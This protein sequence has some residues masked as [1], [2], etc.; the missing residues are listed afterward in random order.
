MMA[1]RS[2]NVDAVKVLLDHGAQVNAKDTLRG[3]TALMWATEQ[4]HVGST[5]QRRF[6]PESH[7]FRSAP[8]QHVGNHHAFHRTRW[9]RS[10]FFQIRIAVQ[11]NQAY[12]AVVAARP[13]NG[14]QHDRGV[15]SEHHGQAARLDGHLYLRA[16]FLER[17]QHLRD[18]ARPR[19]L[20]IGSKNP[21]GAIPVIGDLKARR[22]QALH[23]THSTQSGWSFFRTR[24]ESSSA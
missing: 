13:R 16:Q 21:A 4:G 22:L 20:F 5:H 14:G 10:R 11:E 24:H 18:I 8:A 1:S 2:G 15:P 7:Q 3:T 12:V 9:R 23:E 6:A 19:V 17:S